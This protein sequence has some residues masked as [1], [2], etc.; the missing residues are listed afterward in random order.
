MS[1][2][3]RF[4]PEAAANALLAEQSERERVV[5]DLAASYGDILQREQDL[6]TARAEHLQLRVRASEFG[7]TDAALKKAGISTVGLERKPR[8]TNKRR[9]APSGAQLAASAHTSHSD[10]EVG[11]VNA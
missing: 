1:T 2:A 11:S 8:R 10:G 5:R 4:D 7:I 3:I 6:D 9:T